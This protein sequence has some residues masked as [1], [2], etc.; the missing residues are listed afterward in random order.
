MTFLILSS[1]A[2]AFL[3]VMI[4]FSSTVGA[5]FIKRRRLNVIKGGTHYLDEEL[6]KDF[7]QRYFEP[8]VKKLQKGFGEKSKTPGSPAVKSK[9]IVKLQN[10]LQL[11]GIGVSAEAFSMIKMAVT[12]GL[13]VL[14]LI[15]A[16]T[17]KSEPMVKLLIMTAALMMAILIPRYY[18]KS[19]IKS[20]QAAIRNQLPNLMDVLSVS[21]EAGLGFDAALLKVT[22]S[23]KGPLVDEFSRV[24]REIQMGKSRKDSLMALAERSNVE[25]LK[26]FTT[27]VVQSEKYGTPVKNVMKAQ[28]QQLRLTR[29]Q[30]AQEKAAKAPVKMLLPMVVFVFPVVFII[31]MG[32][33]V[34]NMI[35]QFG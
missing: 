25:E 3:L 13:A 9:S 27:A 6:E 18:L 5:E 24:Y 21:I 14:G 1:S 2:L 17:V 16:L 35:D 26:T 20:R 32:P 34:I 7:Y 4:M 22:E 12:L 8:V 28:S 11:A 23:F 33:T 30:R 19:R 29:R 31:L 15:L 10:E